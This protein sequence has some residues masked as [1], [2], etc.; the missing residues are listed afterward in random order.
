MRAIVLG[1]GLQGSA[2]AYD[3]ARSAGVRS[4]RLA[5]A[6]PER[7]ALAC[8]LPGLAG[9]GILADLRRPELLAAEIAG[10]D[11][12]LSALPYFL[13]PSAALACARAGV[14]Y[15]DLGGNPEASQR[16]LDLDPAA[17][18]SGATLVPD[19]GLAPGL[20]ATVS[21]AAIEGFSELDAL[22]IRVGG[23]PQNPAAPLNYALSFSIHGLLNEYTGE[24]W[25]LR[26][27]QLR[28]LAS[29]E[30]LEE[31]ELPP[32]LGLCEA[33]ITRGG[34][35]TLPASLAG[36]ARHLDYKTIRYPG[37]AAQ[38]RLLRD[39][40]FLDEEPVDLDGLPV[41]P[42]ALT[43][44]LLGR[45]LRSA[46]IRDLVVFRCEAEGLLEGRR[47]RRRYDLLDFYDESTGLSA[48]RRCTAFPASVVLQMLGR[49]EGPG[50]GAHRLEHAVAP[51][52]C[53]EELARRGLSFRVEEQD[54]R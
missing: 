31:L 52:P 27:G 34:A 32:P 44:R 26:D 39:L 17:R 12:C 28:R 25:V 20:A 22:R 16:I 54:L 15:V 45:H 8:A 38:I 50:P 1:A 11:V 2:A 53:L 18:A 46:D 37:H 41:A 21:M 47:R 19:C 14:H 49:G 23:L 6:D 33:F 51:A 40:G 30:E 24:D 7:L 13:N 5:D 9:C 35:G 36:R 48:M 3:L 43:A 4:V 29:L 10:S 42:R